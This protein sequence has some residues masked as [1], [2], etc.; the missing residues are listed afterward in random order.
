MKFGIDII[1]WKFIMGILTK[2]G[3]GMNKMEEY[4]F[5]HIHFFAYLWT[6]TNSRTK[7][8]NHMDLLSHG[9]DYM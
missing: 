6:L 5:V 1:V 3:G 9:T 7:D 2:F 8:Y 4:S